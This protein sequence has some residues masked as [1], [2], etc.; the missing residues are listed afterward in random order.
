[1]EAIANRPLAV[2]DLV[3]AELAANG[4]GVPGARVLVVGV[5][6]KP[7]IEDLRE[8]PALTIMSKLMD[9]GAVVD[10]YDPL[11]HSVE[12]ADNTVLVSIADP[13]P[14]SYDAI[15]VNT[16][17][18]NVDYGWL[19]GGQIVIDPSGRSKPFT[20]D[21]RGRPAGQIRAAEPATVS[22]AAG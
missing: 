12:V 11:V 7:G 5:A 1:M 2:V 6:Y 17:H 16:I 13:L 22:S 14:A 18:P 19:S 10:Y 3:G 4:R 8:S 21:G 15:V 9:E 20:S